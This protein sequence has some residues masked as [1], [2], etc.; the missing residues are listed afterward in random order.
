MKLKSIKIE[1]PIE[2][3]KTMAIEVTIETNT[4]EKRWCFFFTPEGMSSCGDFIEGTNVR[5]HYGAPH[6]ILVSKISQ[7]IIKSALRDIE[8]QGEVELCTIPC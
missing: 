5:F 7:S 2:L 4:G 8:N 3:H 1:D 6:M